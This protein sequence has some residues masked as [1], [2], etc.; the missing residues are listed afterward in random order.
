[1]I[2]LATKYDWKL[3]QLDVKSTFLNGDLKEEI[4]LVQPKGFVKKVQEHLLCKLK[5]TLYGLKH[6]PR[7]WYEK[8]DKFFFRKRFNKRKN[9]PNLYVKLDKIGNIVLISIY[10]DDRII[11]GSDDKLIKDIKWKLSQEFEM[12]DLGQMHYCLGLEVWRDDGRT[13]ITQRKYIN[14][15]IKRFHMK[16]CKAVCTLLE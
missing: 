4:Y 2:A 6:A 8:I 11:T 13:L 1:V 3:H 14:E 9:D 10:V 5:M 15:L 7:S 16:V 12:K